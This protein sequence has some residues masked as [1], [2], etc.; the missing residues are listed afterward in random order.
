M[1]IETAKKNILKYS[2]EMPS[3]FDDLWQWLE[4]TKNN[5][6]NILL[7]YKNKK[8]FDDINSNISRF[9]QFLTNLDV[10]DFLKFK[11]TNEDDNIEYKI[12]D[13]REY[14]NENQIIMIGRDYADKY[15]YGA[16]ID[17]PTGTGKLI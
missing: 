6:E 4:I 15:N 8:E 9:I 1:T 13:N 11:L 16:I 10:S 14:I 2:T 12:T 17:T 5:F 3:D 7:K